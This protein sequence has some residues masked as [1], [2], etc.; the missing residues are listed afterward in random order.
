LSARAARALDARAARPAAVEEAM[1]AWDQI[2]SR[3]RS[4]PVPT[5]PAD[6]MW[7]DV[8]RAIRAAQAQQTEPWLARFPWE[9]VTAAAT[10]ALVLGIVI[11]GVRLFVPAQAQAVPRVEWVEA[12]LPGAGAMVYE[13]TASG[14]VVIWLVAPE[15]GPMSG[16][17]Q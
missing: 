14:A 6:V 4:Q 12:A 5:P 17:A 13:D 15:N 3:L 7:Q 16:S 2:G 1:R 11:V 9:W 10:A 8:R